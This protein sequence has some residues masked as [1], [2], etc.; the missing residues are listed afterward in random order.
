MKLPLVAI[1]FSLCLVALSIFQSILTTRD[2][3]QQ[4][5][6]LFQQ[7]LIDPIVKT[8][9]LLDLTSDSPPKD[10]DGDKP[11]TIDK[12]LNIVLLYADDWRHDGRYKYCAA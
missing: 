8:G 9:S 10:D 4:Q 1:G 2:V 11:R 6:S 12:P 3:S 7:Y 5:R